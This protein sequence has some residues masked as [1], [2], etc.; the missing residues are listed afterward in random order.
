MS[1]ARGF[2]VNKSVDS[3]EAALLRECTF[4][5]EVPILIEVLNDKVSH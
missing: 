5:F 4:Q 3:E 1:L 2:Q